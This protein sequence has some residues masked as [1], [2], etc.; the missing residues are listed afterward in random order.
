MGW[1]RDFR[2]PTS[3]KPKRKFALSIGVAHEDY[4]VTNP[5]MSATF[6]PTFYLKLSHAFVR[7]F[8]RSF[9]RIGRFARR[10]QLARLEDSNLILVNN[11]EMGDDATILIHGT[12][13]QKADWT[14]S[15]AVIPQA[16]AVHCVHSSVYRFIWSG[17]NSNLARLKAARDLR[18]AIAG[19]LQKGTKRVHLVGHSHGG[20]VAMLSVRDRETAASTRSIVCLGTPFL[21]IQPRDLNPVCCT[22]ANSISWLIA[23]I[24]LILLLY[25]CIITLNYEF[26]V[27]IWDSV[28][29]IFVITTIIVPALSTV[30]LSTLYL[31]YRKVVR[32]FIEHS[33]KR[34]FR[35]R[36]RAVRCYLAQRTPPCSIF[37]ARIGLDEARVWLRIV[38]FLAD[39]PWI[40]IS[41]LQR[42]LV[43]I[44]L[45]T[46]V[47]YLVALSQSE[48]F[49][50]PDALMFELAYQPIIF[51]LS[52]TALFIFIPI[53]FGFYLL[54]VRGTRF[55]VGTDGVVEGLATHVRI[56][57]QPREPLA[58]KSEIVL[59][60]SRGW[61]LRH[62]S[63][64]GNSK[65][66]E[67][68]GLW[69]NEQIRGPARISDHSQTRENDNARVFHQSIGFS[70]F[71]VPVVAAVITFTLPVVTAFEQ[72][73]A[74]LAAELL[75]EPQGDFDA[76]PPSLANLPWTE[77]AHE[78][79]TV[80]GDGE[81]I[82]Y[83]VD[84]KYAR[85]R[86]CQIE[87][88]FTSS[89]WKTSMWSY[90]AEGISEGQSK[91]IQQHGWIGYDGAFYK[92]AEDGWLWDYLTEDAR[93]VH[94]RKNVE[95]ENDFLMINVSNSSRVR[96]KV[97]M[98][99]A[100]RCS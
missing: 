91:K 68:I 34:F 24:F 67:K 37:V 43:G 46:I 49:G 59:A 17:G 36:Q 69:L 75:S 74:F 95:I 45:A 71:I 44:V 40:I 55:G 84:L 52:I 48:S 88:E 30:F 96:A 11:G 60:N 15:G 21:Q 87:G 65:L 2:F 82:V 92:H 7:F 9:R 98:K 41:A 26:T 76:D 8:S 16:I 22:I 10:W 29:S 3:S 72:R 50:L 19:L 57:G 18:Y 33:L 66:A 14:K 47:F 93:R 28:Y 80:E 6:S 1:M 73:E 90:W 27:K 86:N 78:Q 62:S 94:F 35:I 89:N 4:I 25:I 32:G 81:P 70:K 56:L 79:F 83:I 38:A 39:F 23:L 100:I 31:N 64:Y 99:L 85:G 42:A 61:G 12:F 5:S 77:L 20:T 53:F 63:F 13:A 51:A 58:P 54:I 97:S